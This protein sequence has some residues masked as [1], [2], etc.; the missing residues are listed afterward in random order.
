[1]DQNRPRTLPTGC[2]WRESEAG[3]KVEISGFGQPPPG[4]FFWSA[5]LTASFQSPSILN[6]SGRGRV[7]LSALFACLAFGFM[8]GTRTW[9]TAHSQKDNRLR[10]GHL[11][12]LSL[13][14]I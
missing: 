10:Q 6:K 13:L 9:E 1:M 4:G 5:F 11:A 7:L 2:Y 8:G 14:E 3:S 12:R